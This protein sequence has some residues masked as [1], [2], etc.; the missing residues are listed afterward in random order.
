MQGFAHDDLSLSRFIIQ[1]EVRTMLFRLLRVTFLRC[2]LQK[3]Q[4]LGCTFPNVLS[5]QVLNIKVMVQQTHV[6]DIQAAS[7]GGG[8]DGSAPD[9]QDA[10]PQH[11]SPGCVFR[12]QSHALHHSLIH[13]SLGDLASSVQFPGGGLLGRGLCQALAVGDREDGGPIRCPPTQANCNV[14]L[15]HAKSCRGR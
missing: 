6:V 8:E 12:H 11:C 13:G 1:I 3:V 4:M 9:C 14:P 7:G 10:A 5:G 2:F 15:L